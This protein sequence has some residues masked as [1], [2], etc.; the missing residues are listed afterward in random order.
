VTLRFQRREKIGAYC[1]LY[2]VEMTSSMGLEDK[3]RMPLDEL[4]KQQQ[5]K[6]GGKQN[7]TVKPGGR[8]GTTGSGFQVQFS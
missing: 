5:Q 1:S 3:L 7:S 6:S 2:F 4:I 8:T